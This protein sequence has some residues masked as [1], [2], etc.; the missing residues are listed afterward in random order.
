MEK[1]SCVYLCR[2]AS[3]LTCHPITSAVLF[4]SDV[5]FVC[6]RNTKSR[7]RKCKYVSYRQSSGAEMNTILW[8]SI[9]HFI[10]KKKTPIFPIHKNCC[11]ERNILS[12]QGKYTQCISNYCVQYKSTKRIKARYFDQNVASSNQNW[13]L[14]LIF[15]LSKY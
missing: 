10:I 5:F 9:S 3:E 6:V 8:G 11:V 1:Y 7:K 13:Q 12:G 15:M 2:C 14:V 4:I